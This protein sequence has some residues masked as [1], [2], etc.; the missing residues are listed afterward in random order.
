MDIYT[1]DNQEHLSV[2]RNKSVKVKNIDQK[3]ADYTER[4]I[5]AIRGIGIGL[6]APQTGRNECFFVCRL[7]RME[8]MVFINPEITATSED[9]ASYDEGCLSIP[10]MYGEVKRPAA[11]EVQAWNLK[12][13]PFRMEADGLLATCIQHELDHLKGL[14]FID[15]LSE[16][17]R[18]KLLKKYEKSLRTG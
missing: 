9:I 14:L 6:A 2:L 7:D 8:P 18:A 11:I 15:H 13:R 1:I 4:M 16:R 5:R 10:G 17:K 3:L 12:G